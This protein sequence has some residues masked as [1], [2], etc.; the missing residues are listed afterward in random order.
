MRNRKSFLLFPILLLLLFIISFSLTRLP[1][2]PGDALEISELFIKNMGN[3]DYKVGYDL[4]VKEGQNWNDF[5]EFQKVWKDQ[6]YGEYFYFVD[7]TEPVRFYPYQSLGNYYKRLL[8]KRE[9]AR[10]QEIDAICYI[11]DVS[12]NI[13]C[14]NLKLRIV[15]DRWKIVGFRRTAG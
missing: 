9:P 11:K 13:V 3:G 10:Q 6:F 4:A 14:L 8:L 1:Y 15:D 12:D 2:R 5:I 7:F